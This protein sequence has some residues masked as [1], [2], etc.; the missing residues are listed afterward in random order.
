M[1][2][3][4]KSVIPRVLGIF[5]VFTVICGFA[6]PLIV[7]GM[8]RVFFPKQAAGSILIGED[9]TKYGSGLVGQQFTGDK[10]LWGRIMNLDTAT[11]TGKDG[12]PLLYAVPSNMSPAGADYEKLVAERVAHIRKAQPENADEP[13]PVDLVTCSGSGLDP[14]VS[15][16]AAE[17]Q[18]S[19]IARVRGI[20][21]ADVRVVIKKYTKGRVL[22][23]FGEPAV[24]VLKVNLTLDGIRW[25]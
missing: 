14:D 9:G 20:S 5:L 19:R 8:A 16:A 18:V 12:K 15:P 17:F 21:E 2:K 4:M 22:G 1:I 11:F 10:Y 23:I 3:T 7:T 25:K 13:I 24:N 6:F